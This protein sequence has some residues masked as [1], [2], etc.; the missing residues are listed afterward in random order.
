[1]EKAET[2]IEMI[3]ECPSCRKSN[4]VAWAVSYDNN[5]EVWTCENCGVEFEYCH[6][7]NQH[8]LNN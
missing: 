6:P 2:Y 7:G 3:S 8:G 5:Y 4:I 1:M